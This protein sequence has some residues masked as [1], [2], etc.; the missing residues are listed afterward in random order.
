MEPHMELKTSDALT[1]NYCSD[2]ELLLVR[3]ASLQSSLSLCSLNIFGK[4]YA[5]GF[6]R[7]KL[8]RRPSCRARIRAGR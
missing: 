5:C 7:P 8:T 2:T 3:Q 4:Q 1:R 6:R